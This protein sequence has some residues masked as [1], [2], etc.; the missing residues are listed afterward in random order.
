LDIRFVTPHH[1][2]ITIRSHRDGFGRRWKN[3]PHSIIVSKEQKLDW[4][5]RSQRLNADATHLAR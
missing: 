5:I 1:L 3:A 4:V 2:F